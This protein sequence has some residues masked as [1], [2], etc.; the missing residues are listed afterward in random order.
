MLALFGLFYFII[1]LVFLASAFFIVY[2]LARY[3]F[4]KDAMIL[5]LAIFLSV[6]F[7]LFFAN[8]VLFFSVDWQE[9]LPLVLP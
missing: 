4:H 7:A 6:F 3:T 2:H 8:L 1:V 5:S 9:A